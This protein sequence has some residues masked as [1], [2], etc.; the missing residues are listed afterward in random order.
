MRIDKELVNRNFFESRSKAVFA[1]LNSEVYC[2]DK[3]ITKASFI[4]NDNDVLTMKKSRLK[5]VSKGGLKLEKAISAFNIDLNNKVVID[6]GSSTGGFCDCAL[7]NNAKK[8]YAIDVGTSQLHEKLRNDNRVVAY[9][10]TDFRNIDNNLVNDAT[11]A[12]IDV[13]FISVTKLILKLDEL[14]NINEIICLIKPQFEC[15]KEIADKY[16]GVPLN[17]KIHKNV[18]LNVINSFNNINYYLNGITFSGIRGGDGNIEYI[19]YF[20]KDISKNNEINIDTVI[21]TAF[22]S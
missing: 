12:T 19:A 17:K 15:G 16:K 9:E 22:N 8:I 13:S 20:R 2:N 7:M 4:V 5:Y 11:I 14:N 18:L 1:I 21:K 3:L 6:I 10:Q